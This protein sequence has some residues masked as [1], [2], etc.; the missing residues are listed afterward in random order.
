[1]EASPRGRRARKRSGAL[2]L[3]AVLLTAACSD[4]DEGSTASASASWKAEGLRAVSPLTGS[5]DTVAVVDGS[6]PDLQMVV[7]DAATGQVRFKRPWSTAGQFPGM[8]VGSPAVVGDVV[9][10]ME[11]WGPDT[12]LVAFDAHSGEERWR[13]GVPAQTFA[14]WRC[15]ELVCSV[16]LPEGDEV[17]VARDPATGTP[18]RTSPGRNVATAE[19]DGTQVQLQL[20]TPV[21]SLFDPAAGETRWS[22]DLREPLGRLATT[23][24][25]WHF[26][27]VG[28]SVVVSLWNLE[29]VGS[30]VGVDRSTGAVRWTRRGLGMC[31]A[32]GEDFVLLCDAAHEGVVYR[33][34]PA[35]GAVQWSVDRL[36]VP[37]GGREPE[38]SLAADRS[39]LFGMDVANRPVS[40]DMVTGKRA[41]P[42][43]GALGWRRVR[44]EG[45][46]VR[47]STSSGS[48]VHQYVP[49]YALVPWDPVANAPGTH[50]ATAADVPGYAALDLAGFRIFTD[51]A[52]T[53]QA[54]QI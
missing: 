46:E 19:K 45:V 39:T 49:S 10:S 31:P 29:N 51:A 9:V 20:G 32:S 35:T 12:N 5:G 2:F 48:S 47:I 4:K 36:A 43:P 7:L 28:D 54:L 18:I 1:M 16:Q 6:T 50:V 23:G 21:V 37:D 42:E 53:V 30:T 22:T 40:I 24:A 34:E 13:I 11:G 41:T 3:V 33:V 25:G 52:G 26:D 15:E 8:G 27:T 17:R 44:G 14:P 38:L